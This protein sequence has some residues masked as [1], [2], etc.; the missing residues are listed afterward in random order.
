LILPFRNNVAP[1]VPNS[2][3][4]ASTIM[5]R[6]RKGAFPAGESFFGPPEK[7]AQSVQARQRIMTR[8]N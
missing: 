4:L 6:R 8:A 3:H 2:Y 7:T 5:P 1:N